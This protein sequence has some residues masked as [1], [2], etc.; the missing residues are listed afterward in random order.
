MKETIAGL[1]ATTQLFMGFDP[2]SPFLDSQGPIAPKDALKGMFHF[3]EVNLSYLTPAIMATWQCIAPD[4][5]DAIESNYEAMEMV[6]DADRLD[7]CGGYPQANSV[8]KSMVRVNGFTQ[9]VDWLADNIVL[10]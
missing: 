7:S 5:E 3:N 9:T 2:K 10:K 8:M 1:M 6:I 4:C